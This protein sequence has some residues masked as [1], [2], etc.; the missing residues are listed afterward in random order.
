M[1]QS[2]V[3]LPDPGSD[4]PEKI[5]TLIVGP[6]AARAPEGLAGEPDT[7]ADERTDHHGRQVVTVVVTDY[8]GNPPDVA[9]HDVWSTWSALYP[10]AVVEVVHAWQGWEPVR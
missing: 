3:P 1:P 2:A 7:V 4:P 8:A 5:G 10:D 6:W 9:A